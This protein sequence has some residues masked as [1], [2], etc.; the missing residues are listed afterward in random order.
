[1]TE[2]V[3]AQIETAAH[4][5]LRSL[6]GK[7][8]HA[9]AARVR[10]TRDAGY[11]PMAPAPTPEIT[12]TDEQFSRLNERREAQLAENRRRRAA[13]ETVPIAPGIGASIFRKGTQGFAGD[14]KLADVWPVVTDNAEVV[15]TIDRVAGSAAREFDAT[16]AG[17]LAQEM[18][19]QAVDK[20]L[21]LY[22][23]ERSLAARDGRGRMVAAATGLKPGRL[24]I[25]SLMPVPVG[26]TAD[27]WMNR[28]ERLSEA[29]AAAVSE[30][31]AGAFVGA[32]ARREVSG[33]R[34]G[35]VQTVTMGQ[36]AARGADFTHELTEV[37]EAEVDRTER[38]V[39]ARVAQR[40]VIAIAIATVT[41]EI[42]R[43]PEW[44]VGDWVCTL[45]DISA[46]QPGERGGLLELWGALDKKLYDKRLYVVKKAKA[47]LASRLVAAGIT[48]E[49]LAA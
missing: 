17:D 30:E 33:I 35:A 23:S 12:L 49:L 39:D 5:F 15:E 20:W 37:H 43:H 6:T 14:V 11:T 10:L 27:W 29:A 4:R 3:P 7:E 22:V 24:G 48:P 36:K 19:I 42:A 31:S 9:H 8:A 18:M 32:F 2:E 1:M 45:K 41:D 46:H 44:A 21:P 26:F 13:G 28:D 16:I 47:L 40:D 25:E 38:P 34:D